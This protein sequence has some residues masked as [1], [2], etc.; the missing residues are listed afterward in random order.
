MA[1]YARGK[2]SLSISDRSGL[3]TKYTKL[4]TTWDGLRVSPEDWEPKH[5]QLTPAR[6]IIDAIALHDPR[7][8]NDPDNIVI[9]LPIDN[10]QIPEYLRPPTTIPGIGRIGSPTIFAANNGTISVEGI[11][12]N[13]LTGNVKLALGVR[14]PGVF[15][16]GIVDDVE[17]SSG[18]EV[19]IDG[20][21]GEGVVD[22]V[23]I[24]LGFQ[25]LGVFG[26][27][28]VDAVTVRANANFMADGVFGEGNVNKVLVSTNNETEVDGISG[29]GIVNNDVTFISGAIFNPDGLYGRG[30]VEEV[31]ILLSIVSEGVS[32]IGIV[33]DAEGS[34]NDVVTATGVFGEGIVNNDVT[35][36]A[37]AEYT[38]TGIGTIGKINKV[39]IATNDMFEPFGVSGA[40]V[41]NNDL[42]FEID[43]FF[44]LGVIRGGISC[45]IEGPDRQNIE[46][47]GIYSATG[48]PGV[49]IVDDVT[50]MANADFTADG[51]FGK[52][53]TGNAK[54]SINDS[55][56]VDGTSGLGAVSFDGVQTGSSFNAD[57]VFGEGI[58]N[59]DVSFDIQIRPDG[60]FG[61][62]IVD[63]V[64]ARV[65]S[66]G[67]VTA[68][69]VVGLGV[70]NRVT[71]STNN[72]IEAESIFGKGIV[73]DVTIK[74]NAEYN[75]VGVIGEGIVDDVSFDIEIRSD[76]VFGAG[77]VNNGVEIS[78]GILYESRSVMG[79]GAIGRATFNVDIALTVRGIPA[80]LSLGRSAYST[81][82]MI[83][84]VGLFGTGVVNNDVTFRTSSDGEFIAAQVEL[85]TNAS[86]GDSD[87]SI[88]GT[89]NQN[90]IPVG[91]PRIGQ[92][93][94]TVSG[95]FLTAQVELRA[96]ASIGE[97][98]IIANNVIQVDGVNGKGIVHKVTV[99]T[100]DEFEAESIFRKGVVD[101]V[102]IKAVS[103][104]NPVG[105]F[106]R[107]A[108]NY[109][110]I[111]AFSIYNA[112]GLFGA[113]VV[114]NVTIVANGEADAI[115]VTGAGVVN[116]VDLSVSSEITVIGI[117]GKG[118]V[119]NDISTE[120]IY[121]PW[122]AWAS[123]SGLVN[124]TGG[125]SKRIFDSDNV[126]NIEVLTTGPGFFR[127][128]FENDIDPNSVVFAMTTKNV[129]PPLRK[130]SYPYVVT[131]SPIGINGVVL[132]VV[133]TG[134]V[135]DGT[136]PFGAV[137]T[138]P[139]HVETDRVYMGVLDGR[140]N[141]K[142]EYTTVVTGVSGNGVVDYYKS[143]KDSP[144]VAW[145]SFSGLMNPPGGESKRIFDSHNV[146]EI[147]VLTAGPGFF[148]VIF[149]RDI[150]PNATLFGL[151]TKNVDPPLV[152]ASYPYVVTQSPIGTNGAVIEIVATGTVPDGTAP[153]GAVV[154]IPDHVETGRVFIAIS[155]NLN[156]TDS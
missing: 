34:I 54:G 124:P 71:I 117:S 110:R 40:G 12:G 133:A 68:R 76:G 37:A 90:I 72:V 32:G 43:V 142:N 101:D 8:D 132:E 24:S 74:A 16:E 103:L 11:Y 139:D 128:N 6:N 69:S 96:Y 38:A 51:V 107:G 152:K 5:P 89:R 75:A 2:R 91:R 85:R 79:L 67:Q 14:A 59:N 80:G 56:R 100:N 70:V 93:E 119:S 7:P 33:D 28:I 137:V 145:A 9:R 45:S 131:Q 53:L 36:E 140:N 60:V 77:V 58:V 126:K 19:E 49:G 144:W 120:T 63:N 155:G 108:V 134:T 121:F 136:A 113:G 97:V 102:T 17:I 94:Y 47:S 114:N 92:P 48:V 87:I 88:G 127:V 99:A 78:T 31:Q 115:G 112:V 46:L 1:R 39:S 73:D 55:Y 111:N 151:T 147:E 57:G 64:T 61:D 150:E 26:E 148:R 116:N 98:N 21:F 42:D 149:D 125:E 23:Q 156:D 153:F 122:A 41:V 29:A 52:G 118:V 30:R 4:K 82:N 27:G 15:G 135:P 35:F 104:Y 129:A 18:D 143:E 20:V 66:G 81:G 50:V 44:Y 138:I 22:D 65:I 105:L 25:A 141:R 62:G 3:R 10:W 154:T 123:F 146:R 106:G 83:E 130:A 109:V 13:G 95:E 84:P 86:I